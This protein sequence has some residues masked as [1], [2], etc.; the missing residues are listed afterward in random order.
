MI[1]RMMYRKATVEVD[2]TVRPVPLAW[3]TYSSS[4]TFFRTTGLICQAS[5][6]GTLCVVLNSLPES[7]NTLSGGVRCNP[8]PLLNATYPPPTTSK[9]R[10]VPSM[11]NRSTAAWLIYKISLSCDK[12]VE[13]FH[14][15]ITWGVSVHMATCVL[16]VDTLSDIAL[17]VSG[18]CPGLTD[19]TPLSLMALVGMY[20][21][22]PGFTSRDLLPN[23]LSTDK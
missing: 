10:G 4:R 19:V 14:D 23:Q 8:K 21:V 16:G 6:G 3:S 18:A 9:R 7:T 13:G 17:L 15:A 22:C 1:L 11:K 20:L 5:A 12:G 2:P